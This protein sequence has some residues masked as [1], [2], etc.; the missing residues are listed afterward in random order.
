MTDFPYEPLKVLLRQHSLA[1]VVVN[2]KNYRQYESFIQTLRI[3]DPV[4]IH[5]GVESLSYESIEDSPSK[6]GIFVVDAEEHVVCSLLLDFACEATRDHITLDPHRRALEIF[7]ACS[8]KAHRVP[9]LMQSLFFAVFDKFPGADVW[10]WVSKSEQNAS[11][12]T[13]YGDIVGFTHVPNTNYAMVKYSTEL[14]PPNPNRTTEPK[15][16]TGGAAAAKRRIRDKIKMISQGAY[17]CIYK[18]GLT[19]SGKPNNSKNFVS[20]LQKRNRTADNEIAIGKIVMGIP[21][22]QYRYAP[23]VQSCPVQLSAIDPIY[24]KKC[25]VAKKALATKLQGPDLFTLNKIKYAG[26]ETLETY[27]TR[28]LSSG[29]FLPKFYEMHLY[30]LRSIQLLANA[31]VVHYDL[32]ENNVMYDASNHT[33]VIIDFGLSLDMGT[34]LVPRAPSEAYK[35]AFYTHYEKYPPW[36]LDI[37]LASYIVQKKQSAN[38]MTTPVDAVE[39]GRVVDAYF[40]TNGAILTIADRDQGAVN[41]SRLAWRQVAKSLDKLP[42]K[43]AVDRLAATWKSWDNFGIAVIFLFLWAQYDLDKL[44]PS[45]VSEQY[46][47]ALVI[48]I[49]SLPESRPTAAASYDAMFAMFQ[50]LTRSSYQS[51]KK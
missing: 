7:L 47:A 28:R 26:S 44:D 51:I 4:I 10:L 6:Y 36:C 43:Q 16:T 23:V 30:L 11:A 14:P 32:K 19:C 5:P 1:M 21:S 15:I 22:Y 35:N 18:P 33:P 17:G 49:L 13:F 41:K 31:N 42:G 48:T 25:D 3:C 38:W 2:Q 27:L 9:R 37:V 39:L 20:K 8:D 50:K 45:P 24:V 34:I 29:Y 46:Y 40:A 12:L